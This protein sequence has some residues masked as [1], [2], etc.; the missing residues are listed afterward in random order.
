MARGREGAQALTARPSLSFMRALLDR[1]DLRI[2][3]LLA[4]SAEVGPPEFFR[5]PAPDLLELI[6]LGGG[7]PLKSLCPSVL[8]V[9]FSPAV[10]STSSTAS[11]DDVR[12][13]DRHEGV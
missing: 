9:S 2:R 4:G 5:D 10:G 13:V 1:S 12:F 3:A 8:R 11:S 6:G 7:N